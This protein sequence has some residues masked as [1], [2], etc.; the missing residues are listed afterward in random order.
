VEKKRFYLFLAILG[1]F[2]AILACTR[3]GSEKVVY[4][5]A[6]FP[7]GVILAS[8]T[9]NVPTDTPIKPT[10]NPARFDTPVAVAGTT[11]GGEQTYTVQAGDTLNVIAQ[12]F[13]T[14]VQAIL[15]L[16]GLTNPDLLEVGQVLQIPAASN[17]PPPATGFK[18]IPDSELVYSPSVRDFDVAA[19]VKL[20]PG[21]LRVY[22]EELNG[23]LWSGVELVNQVALDYSINPR[24]LLALIEYQSGWLS[25]PNPSEDAQNYPFGIIALERVGL[26]RQL[27]SAANTLNAGYY[28]WKY[29]GLEAASFPDG[30][31]L[32]FATDLN[33]G[34][35]A[36][37]FFFSQYRTPAQYQIDVSE[38]GF[39]QTYLS[40]FGDP[41]RS[42]T[43]PLVPNDLR[44]PEFNFPFPRG[45]TWYFTGGPHG[46]YNTGSAWSSV[47]FAPPTPSD[48]LV[49]Q[50]GFCY[51]STNWT[52]AVA[53]GVVARSGGG[54]VILD[55]DGDGNEHTGWTVV[56]LHISSQ[57]VIK[58]GTRVE[59][60]DRLGHPSCEG[61]YSTGTH[62]HFGRRFNGEWIPVSCER[63]PKGVSVPPLVL[64]GWTVFGY[65]NA[66]YQ[67]YMTN[68]NGLER[69]ANVGREDPINQVS[70]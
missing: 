70:W 17:P 66:E 56:Y 2:G 40:L 11:G 6:T 28:G 54:Y 13:G 22:S 46:G 27:L 10:P 24:L 3:P 55:L 21:F 61:G 19:Y 15:A 23:Q 20:K 67:G 12:R 59:A 39:F 69:R 33:A 63:C 41:F 1:L 49:A 34:T 9:P 32:S 50:Q 60:G 42:A 31:P 47:D 65:P 29:R 16:N 7:G 52:A 44:Q 38:Q 68:E 48:E 37:Q 58:A 57:D 5:T 35:V 4:V 53:A 43:E 26:W 18:T 8:E 30:T 14:S 45:E 62:L 36:V 25:N 64:S 51:I